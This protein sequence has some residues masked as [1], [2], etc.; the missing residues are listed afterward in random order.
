MAGDRPDPVLR[1]GPFG[2]S[3]VKLCRGK[4]ELGENI[5]DFRQE[6]AYTVAT[7]CFAAANGNDW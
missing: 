4:G 2:L 3:N 1:G 7:R 6:S 5:G